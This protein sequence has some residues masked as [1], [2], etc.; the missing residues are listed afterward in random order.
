MS[1]DDYGVGV[2]L[3]SRTKKYRARLNI[4]G[5]EY[6]LGYHFTPQSAQSAINS[7]LEADESGRRSIWARGKRERNAT[8]RENVKTA[9][10]HRWGNQHVA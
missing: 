5:V 1:T 8:R 10:Q 7:F 4:A 2:T 3:C 6:S 9:Q